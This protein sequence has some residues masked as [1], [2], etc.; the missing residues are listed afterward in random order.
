[1][2]DDEDVCP[3]CGAK[4]GKCREDAMLRSGADGTLHTVRIVRLTDERGPMYTLTEETYVNRDS[5]KVAKKGSP[6]SA[7]LLGMAGDEIS[8]ETAKRL[9]LLEA[10]ADV[11]SV[12]SSRYA[13]MTKAELVAEAGDLDVGPKPTKADLVSA[14][15][16]RDAAAEANA[17]GTGTAQVEAPAE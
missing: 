13:A 11:E 5:T 9:G 17:E 3:V 2:Y 12:P 16:E 8:E 1:M 10:D 14:L 15:E 7:Y 6:E 4:N